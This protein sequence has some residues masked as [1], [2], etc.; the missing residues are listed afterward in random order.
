[1]ALVVAGVYI[2]Y[3]MLPVIYHAYVWK[4]LMQHKVDVAATQGYPAKWVNDQLRKSA[5]E[6]GVPADAEIFATP[7]DQRIAVRV[8]Y[9]TLVEFPGYT[10]EYD[11]DH[12]ARSTEFLSIK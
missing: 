10:Y 5:A 12:T 1:M 4:D 9:K 8:Q 2:G 7:Q 3:Q 11:F 6:Y